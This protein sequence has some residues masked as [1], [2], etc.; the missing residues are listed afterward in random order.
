MSA[1]K[2]GLSAEDKRKKILEIFFETRDFF[3]FKDIEKLATKRGV[4]QQ[5]VKE[6]LDGLVSDRLVTCE[7][8]GIGNYY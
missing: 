3:P 7:K 5:A 8:I 6:V 4:V 1:K 2:K